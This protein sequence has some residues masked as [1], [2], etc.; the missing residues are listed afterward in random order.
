RNIIY[1]IEEPETSQHP[2][3]QRMIIHS[4]SEIAKNNGHQVFITTHTPEIA[5]LVDKESLIL[6]KSDS[7]G[8]RII[9]DQFFKM[10]EIA[11]TLGI[12]PT[13]HANVVVC[14]EGPNDVNFI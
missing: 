3:Y 1:A 9:T 6:V 4:L 12:L 7:E 14:V 10:N 5:Q 8:T 2:N 11:K 13:I